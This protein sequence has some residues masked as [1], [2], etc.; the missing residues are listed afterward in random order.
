MTRTSNESNKLFSINFKNFLNYKAEIE[1]DK[2]VLFEFL[3]YNHFKFNR[4]FNLSGIDIETSLGIKR[5]RRQKIV[6]EF[7]DMGFLK[8]EART[9]IIEGNPRRSTYYKFLPDEMQKAARVLMKNSEVFGNR[10]R[11]L[12]RRNYTTLGYSGGI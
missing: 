8:V 9:I 10:I 12:L 5:G 1:C 4:E 3:L 11:P 6:G 2:R 7:I